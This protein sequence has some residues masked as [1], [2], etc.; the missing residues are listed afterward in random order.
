[1][2]SLAN[3]TVQDRIQNYL[4]N[5]EI[6]NFQPTLKQ[7]QSAIKRDVS[8]GWSCEKIQDCIECL[9][10]DIVSNPEAISWSSVVI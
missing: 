4:N 1:M 7:I 5:C 10:Y 8:T 6:R 2:D 9:G 3:T